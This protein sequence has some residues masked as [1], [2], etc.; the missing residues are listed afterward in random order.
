MKILSPSAPIR[1]SLSS[2]A[3]VRKLL[4]SFSV[5]TRAP[6]ENLWRKYLERHRSQRGGES[7]MPTASQGDEDEESFKCD[8]TRYNINKTRYIRAHVISCCDQ[9]H[10]TLYRKWIRIAAV[11]FISKCWFCLYKCRPSPDK[12]DEPVKGWRPLHRHVEN[13]KAA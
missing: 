5:K 7:E 8:K 11:G 9:E 3:A 2:S 1:P 6:G 13:S 4:V 10:V 12:L